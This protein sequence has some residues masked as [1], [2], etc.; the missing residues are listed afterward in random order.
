MIYKPTQCDEEE[1]ED[2]HESEFEKDLESFRQRLEKT[3]LN[4]KKS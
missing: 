2:S 3:G 4:T 1:E